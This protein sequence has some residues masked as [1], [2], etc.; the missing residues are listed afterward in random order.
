MFNS[1]PFLVPVR[2]VWKL[3]IRNQWKLSDMNTNNLECTPPP[4][5]EVNM[6][7]FV[8]QNSSGK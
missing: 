7:S 1:A 8:A 3:Q 4:A 2:L 5:F 6:E